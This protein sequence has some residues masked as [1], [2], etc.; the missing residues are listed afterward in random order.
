[1]SLHF[2]ICLCDA[3]SC[4]T[5]N[6][7]QLATLIVLAEILAL[8][9]ITCYFLLCIRDI[10]VYTILEVLDI[11]AP[12]NLEL[13]TVR[14]HIA[15]VLCRNT[16]TQY[17]RK[18]RSRTY[19]VEGA[20]YEVLERSSESVVQETEV[21]THVPRTNSL[22]TQASTYKTWI[23]CP[24]RQCTTNNPTILGTYAQRAICRVP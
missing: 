14:L 13:K 8:I 22:P 10:E 11:I 3:D 7:T 16:C 18:L 2:L 9:W 21:K 5:P 1:M 20:T 12:T 19:H 17:R 6:V 4:V 23:A 24:V 15:V